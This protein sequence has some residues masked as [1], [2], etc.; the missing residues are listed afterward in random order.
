MGARRPHGDWSSGA[1]RKVKQG[2]AVEK[3]DDRHLK[4]R[5]KSRT[6]DLF[7][8]DAAW[9]LGVREASDSEGRRQAHQVEEEVCWTDKIWAHTRGRTTTCLKRPNRQTTLAPLGSVGCVWARDRR[10]LEMVPMCED[11]NTS[12]RTSIAQQQTGHHFMLFL[13]LGH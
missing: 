4:W 3:Q 7:P 2:S 5:K 11:A 10:P 8:R 6:V 12:S 9:V 1:R 13:D